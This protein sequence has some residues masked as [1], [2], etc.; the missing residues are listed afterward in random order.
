MHWRGKKNIKKKTS[1]IRFL[2]SCRRQFEDFGC[3]WTENLPIWGKKLLYSLH[4]GAKNKIK[5]KCKFFFLVR[6][7]FF[8]PEDL[9][10]IEYIVSGLT[11]NDAPRRAAGR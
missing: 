6:D 8:S 10:P 9:S 2:F 5:L 4:A 1:G 3:F 7:N 11:R